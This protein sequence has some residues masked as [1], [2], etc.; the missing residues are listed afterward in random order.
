MVTRFPA[1]RDFEA[2][3]I[4]TN[5]ATMSLL[6]STRLAALV[7]DAVSQDQRSKH[8][9]VVFPSLEHAERLNRTPADA[10]RLILNAERHL[11]YMAIPFVLA[12]YSTFIVDVI[13][14][15]RIARV[16]EHTNDPNR[17]MLGEFHDY[18]QQIGLSLPNREKELF[19]F[20][21]RIRN[22]IIHYGG[23]EGSRLRSAFMG[24]SSDAQQLWRYLSGGD[25]PLGSPTEQLALEARHLTPA[26]AVTNHLGEAVNVALADLIPSGLWAD[27]V[28]QD[29]TAQS[30]PAGPAQ[31]LRKLLGYARFYYGGL[32]LGE[33]YLEDAL[34]RHLTS[35]EEEKGGSS[36]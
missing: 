32:G 29:F 28:V 18:L 16:D 17:L 10:A 8:L 24:M 19:D 6:V 3:R 15:L 22:R 30:V 9:P 11:T 21:R 33:G 5:D 34:G 2:S 20:I 25:P 23:I 13:Q 4:A 36:H 27:I 7:L 12:V 31:R 26:L 1:Y 35:L 14:M